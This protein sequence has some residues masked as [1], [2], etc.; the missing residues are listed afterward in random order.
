MTRKSKR[1]AINEA[2]RQGQ[3]KIAKG[4][5]TGQMSSDGPSGQTELVGRKSPPGPKKSAYRPKK[6]WEEILKSKEKSKMVAGLVAPRK[7]AVLLYAGAVVVL[8]LLVWTL[9]AIMGPDESPTA[10][11]SGSRT[12]AETGNLAA[13]NRETSHRFRGHRWA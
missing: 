12:A 2:I 10:G 8:G 4:L 3:A 13:G 11:I 1:L 9:L 5:R 6:S 7:S